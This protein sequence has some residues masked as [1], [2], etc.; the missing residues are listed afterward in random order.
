MSYTE[1]ATHIT[2]RLVA[3]IESGPG[4]WQMPWHRTPG[5]LDAR[6][7]A[8][9]NRYRGA[10]TIVLAVTAL[11][12]SYPSRW[13]ATYRQWTELGAQVLRGETATRVVK[14][15][16][17]RG[18]ADTDDNEAETANNSDGRG[19]LVPRVY[20][21]FNAAQVHGW[22]P[23]HQAPIDDIERDARAERWIANT[24]AAIGYGFDHACYRPS[25]DRIEIPAA[26]QFTSSVGFYSVVCHELVHW[27]G[28]T[29]RL[30]RDLTGR[31]GSDAYAAE[32]LVA[33]LG[34]A[35]ACAHLDIASTGRD[36]HAAYLAHW[37]RILKADPK[38][39][40]AVA[41]KAQTAVDWLDGLQLAA[42]V[43]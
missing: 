35:I 5:V 42:V 19:L 10:N 8:T 41:A 28:H 17:G 31:F 27:S 13:W 38:A 34:A 7:A 43:V 36:D 14:W 22:T 9:T 21:V 30:A 25:V 18:T 6:N 16:P 11:D 1:L 23:T 40:F 12:R 33:E 4:A 15:I 29:S 24:G 37:L 26:Q 20:A 32:E 39:L 3:Q 2:A